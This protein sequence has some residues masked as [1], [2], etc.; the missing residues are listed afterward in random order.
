MLSLFVV[1]HFY[2][3][4]RRVLSYR[5]SIVSPDTD[6]TSISG[7]LG[8]Q[9]VATVST[10]PD[11]PSPTHVILWGWVV[12]YALF[13]LIMMGGNGLVIFAVFRYQFLQTITNVFVVGVA[14]ADVTFGITG[15]MKIVDLVS[16]H[17]LAGYGSC[18]L[19]LSMGIINGV[20]TGTMLLC[21]YTRSSFLSDRYELGARIN[22]V[23]YWSKIYGPNEG[24]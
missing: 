5:M 17:L 8:N 18:L 21:K 22:Y 7:L 24:Q 3:Q 13:T 9:T 4:I 20:M 11:T 16:P 10:L 19:R 12:S 15:M 6:M 14:A 23:K 2:N 1:F